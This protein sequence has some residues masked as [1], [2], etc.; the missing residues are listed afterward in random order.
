VD[1]ENNE[2]INSMKKEMNKY[3]YGM[4]SDEVASLFIKVANLE[5][6]LSKKE[7]IEKELREL[8]VQYRDL[9]AAMNITLS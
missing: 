1:T 5:T 7:S 6:N 2:R 4:I 9:L 8:E 3:D